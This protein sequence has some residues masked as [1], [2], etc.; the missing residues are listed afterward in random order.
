MSDRINLQ[1]VRTAVNTVLDHL[2]NDLKLSTVEIDPQKDLYWH[3][4]ANELN[5]MSKAPRGSG[6]GEI[7]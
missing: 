2:V 1:Q 7:E 6:R 3:V 4:P 5:D